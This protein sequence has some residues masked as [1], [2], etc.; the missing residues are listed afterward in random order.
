MC[1]L[2]KSVYLSRDK[3]CL[4]WSTVLF[5]CL[6]PCLTWSTVLFQCLGPCLTWSTVLF[7]CLGGV[8]NSCITSVAAIIEKNNPLHY[9]KL[10]SLNHCVLVIWLRLN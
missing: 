1:I 9:T 2:M 4:T 3:P 6:G 7:Q 10:S 8:T 5:Q